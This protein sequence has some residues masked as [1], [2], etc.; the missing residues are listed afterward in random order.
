VL[1][2]LDGFGE[3]AETEDNAV[4]LARA[5]VLSAL[6]ARYPNATLQT[7]GAA[8][9]LP[10][11][12]MGNS[13]VGHLNFGAGRVAKTDLVRIDG[14]IETGR[15]FQNEVFRGPMQAA[16][17]RGGRVHVM[18]L[19]SDGGVHSSIGHVVA[20][21]DLAHR[22]NVPAV[23]HAFLDGRDTPPRSAG[24]FLEELVA[25]L[26]PH[27]RFGTVIGRYYAMDRDRR[28]DRTERAAR[29][30]ALAEG[31]VFPDPLAALSAAYAAGESDE[32]AQPCVI[33]GY[34]GVQDGRDVGIHANFRAD[35]ARQLTRA[36]ATDAFDGFAR[37][38]GWPRFA[39]FAC[40]SRYDETLDLPVAY[41]KQNV[42]GTLGELV[43]RAGWRQLRCAETEKY[44]HVTYFFNGGEEA[45]FPGEERVLVPSPKD[46]ATYDQKP[47]MSAGRVADVV[48]EAIGKG[49]Y[50]FILVNFANPDMVGHSGVLAAAIRAVEVVDESLGRIV[51]AARAAGAAVLVTADHGNCE[52]MRDPLTGGPHTAHTTFPVPIVLV[53]DRRVGWGLRPGRIADVAPTI[54]EILGLPKPDAMTG[55]S[56]LQRP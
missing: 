21:L 36:L 4:R 5:P 24:R 35:R 13:E 3:R 31:P 45:P 43:S 18:G 42:A 46:V 51:E 30:I 28:W 15:F 22:E 8:V 50:A 2:I 34:A 27:D 49:E 33:A 40:T 55:V 9:G 38:P 48:V 29:A 11:G 10:E 1:V 14:E 25:A 44:A 26:G 16:R 52:L 17:A 32:F 19:A 23:V 37:P 7:S 39:A 20:L 12:Q 53:D 54:L 6:R 56:L 41:P 47:E